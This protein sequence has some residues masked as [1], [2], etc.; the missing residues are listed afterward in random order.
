MDSQHQGYY[1]LQETWQLLITKKHFVINLK[2]LKR[3]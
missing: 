1:S 3:K 2:G